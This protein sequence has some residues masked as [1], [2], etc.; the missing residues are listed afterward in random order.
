MAINS[1]NRA[2][3]VEQTRQSR[4]QGRT[5]G[6][7]SKKEEHPLM[8]R[9]KDIQQMVEYWDLVEDIVE[10]HK[11]IKLGGE[12]YLPRFDGETGSDY[13]TRVEHSK[14]TNIYRDVLEGL[15]TKPFEDLVKLIDGEIPEEVSEFVENVDGCG[16]TLTVF[17]S[18]TFFNG[19]NNAI[20]WILVDYPVVDTD[21]VRTRADQK[22]AGIRPFWSH[23]LAKNVLEI[24]TKV[25]NREEYITYFRLFEPA[26][27]LESEDRVKVYEKLDS[28]EVIWTLYEYNPK[29]K[30]EEDMFKQIDNGMISIGVIPFVPFSTGR[31]NG[32]TWKFYPPMS[33][34]ADLQITLYRNESSLEFIKTMAGYPMLAANGIK[35]EKEADGSTNKKISIGPMKVLYGPPDG[36]GNHGEWAFIEPAAMSMEFLKKDIDKTKQDLREL[37]RQPLTSMSSQL[38]TVTTSIAAGKA[39]SAVTAWALAL[40]DTLINALEM[41]ML[42]MKIDNYEPNV[43][44]FTGF[45]NVLDSSEDIDALNKARD[46]G[47]I[48][49]ETYLAEYKRRK[50]LSPDFNI[51][52]E[53]KRILDEVP[54]EG[55]Q[56]VDSP[57]IDDQNDE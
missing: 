50:I 30:D 1:T 11:A 54:D 15:A 7:V 2:Q 25:I 35:P 43:H 29:G 23:V 52:E 6:G 19:I 18:L 48:S 10:G 41:T 38:T 8:Q 9:G 57:L 49:Q 31:K 53:N 40:Q 28:G 42:W 47:D 12:K 17:S 37:G 33:D 51:D 56:G 20:D 27:D 26:P 44:V 5:T 14:F 39:K 22:A 21:K 45:D 32:S 24:R 4:A 3:L 34:A 36:E 55:D 46:R 13:K 16:N